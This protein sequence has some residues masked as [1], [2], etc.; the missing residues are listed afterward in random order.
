MIIMNSFVE[1]GYFYREQPSCNFVDYLKSFCNKG[2]DIIS[3]PFEWMIFQTNLEIENTNDNIV[4][5]Q[6]PGSV[7][8]NDLNDFVNLKDS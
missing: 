7:S 2:I 3:L 5:S 8:M 4:Y 6:S 1:Y